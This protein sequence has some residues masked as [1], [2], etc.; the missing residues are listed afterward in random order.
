VAEAEARRQVDAWRIQRKSLRWVRK[1]FRSAGLAPEEIE[2][3][4]AEFYGE[5]FRASHLLINYFAPRRD[6]RR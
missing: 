4:I 5:A 1:Q 2:A 3:L 6:G